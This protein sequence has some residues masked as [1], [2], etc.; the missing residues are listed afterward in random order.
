MDIQVVSNILYCEVLRY[1]VLF[2]GSTHVS[3]ERIRTYICAHTWNRTHFYGPAF[4]EI[5][6]FALI[7]N[8]T[9]LTF[10]SYK[11]SFSCLA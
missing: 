9:S 5:L 10:Q 2:L 11:L 3:T 7:N 4:S 1:F 6:H 8:S